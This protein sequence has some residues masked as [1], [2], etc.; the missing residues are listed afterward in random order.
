MN[1]KEFKKKKEKSFLGYFVMGLIGAILGGFLVAI[2]VPGIFPSNEIS[3][4]SQSLKTETENKTK[5][6]RVEI[7]TDVSAA[8]TTVS[9]SVVGVV[10]TKL[11]NTLFNQAETQG[12][13]SGVIVSEKGYI[14]TNN[15]VADM[16]SSSIKVMTHDGKEHNAKPIW[17]D[18]S[19]D[20]S[21][22]KIEAEGLSSIK[23][24]NSKS[25][26]VGEPAIA[27]GNPLGLT[28][29]RSVTSGIVSAVNRT[30]EIERGVFME[31][32]IQTDASINP[33]NSGGALCNIKGEVIGINTAKVSTAEGIGFA[34]PINIIKP[35]IESVEATGNF[36]T[37]YIGVSGF[38][39]EISGYYGY[40][41]KSGIY[42]VK[43]DEGSPA[44]EAGIVSGDV[45]TTVDNEEINTVMEFKEKLFLKK[46]GD[47]MKIKLNAKNNEIK[48]ID[49]KVS[50]K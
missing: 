46:N 49:V 13:G 44:G 21:I 45:I 18:A 26:T 16:N 30:L 14:L 42:V 11:E 7:K 20:L 35:V 8:A 25:L 17:A 37:P 43:V 27:I 32:L 29:Q 19:L 40:D 15:H 4:E 38:D 10:T 33:G 41:I 12:V 9:P 34:V 23:M 48:E 36:I 6:E 5:E 47:T 22:I 2:L 39:R 24:G 31:D 50:A 28:F 1:F 3:K